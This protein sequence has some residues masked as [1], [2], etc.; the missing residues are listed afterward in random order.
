MSVTAKMFTCISLTVALSY[1]LLAADQRRSAVESVREYCKLDYEGARLQMSGYDQIG[2]L[3]DWDVEPGWDSAVV[4]KGFKIKSS[5]INGNDAS[6]SVEYTK[7][8]NLD[9]SEFLGD[10]STETI[11]FRL[12]KVSDTWKLTSPKFPPH[13]SPSA[14]VEHIGGLITTEGQKSRETWSPALE[15]LKS[16]AARGTKVIGPSSPK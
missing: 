9:G 7:Y 12:R 10:Q 6:V 4:T 14:L 3:T 8:G 2:K 16:L 5:L 1:Q 15:K 11:T 13:V